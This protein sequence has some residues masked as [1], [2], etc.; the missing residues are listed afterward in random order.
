MFYLES[1]LLII[2][3]FKILLRS[4][5]HSETFQNRFGKRNRK[6]EFI[7]DLQRFNNRLAGLFLLISV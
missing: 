1:Y 7:R 2:Q 5:S 6:K 4:S 3:S